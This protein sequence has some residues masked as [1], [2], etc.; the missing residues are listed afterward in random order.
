MI[1]LN[2]IYGWEPVLYK[3]ELPADFPSDL[4]NRIKKNKEDGNENLVRMTTLFIVSAKILGNTGRIQIILNSF[5]NEGVWVECHGENPADKEHIGPL[6][7]HP[8]QGLSKNYYPYTNQEGYVSPAVF[9]EFTNPESEWEGCTMV[10]IVIFPID[11]GSDDSH[12]VQGMGSE[13]STPQAGEEGH[14]T[15]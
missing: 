6:V 3:E 2:K 4:K 15:L 10:T 9:V 12:R 11:R 5:Q 13:Y 7:Y 8:D 14:C 1:K